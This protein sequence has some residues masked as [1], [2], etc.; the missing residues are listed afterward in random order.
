MNDRGRLDPDQTEREIAGDV[1]KI[2]QGQ[3]VRQDN[4]DGAGGR[5]RPAQGSR[6]QSRSPQGG[7]RQGAASGD[8]AQGGRVPGSAADR[9]AQ[10]NRAYARGGN[11]NAR[12][13][14]AGQASRGNRAQGGNAQNRRAGRAVQ[15]GNAQSG[16]AGSVPQRRTAGGSRRPAGDPAGSPAGRR[17][18]RGRGRRRETPEERAARIAYEKERKARKRRLSRPYQIISWAFIAIFILLMGNLV[19]F[20]VYEKDSILSSPYNKRQDSLAKFVVRGPIMSSDGQTLA[21]TQENADGT[22]TRIYP[23]SNEYAHVVGYTVNGKGGLE[24]VCNYDLLTAHNNLWDQ[25]VNGF[26]DRRNPGDTVVT[27]LDTRMQD[28]AWNALGDYNGAVVAMEPKTGRI[29]CM[30][31]KP[32][33]DPN[34]LASDWDSIVSDSSSSV[35][36]NRATQGLYAPGSTFKIITSLAYLRAHGTISDFS[37]DCTGSIDVDGNTIHCAGGEVHGTVDFTHAFAESC[38]TAFSE[39]GLETGVSG[40]T[41]AAETFLIGKSLPCDISASKSRWNLTSSDSNYIL[42][43]TA[44]GQAQTSVTPYQMLLITSAVANDGT[45]MTPYLIDRVETD[46]GTVISRTGNK[47]YRRLITEDEASVLKGLMEAVVSEGT[48]TGLSGQSYSAAGKTGTAQYT[49]SDGSTGT[50]SWF[51]GF[52]NVDD[53]DLAVAAIAENGGSGASTAL[54]IVKAVFDTYYAN[55]LNAG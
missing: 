6:G 42:A 22:D 41:D 8:A 53:P 36:L 38:N 12:D 31:S 7:R 52:S 27:T 33:F 14:E 26:E 11:R 23:Y 3:D 51:V 47:T 35:L 34:T 13:A 43:M 2:M 1:R 25:I 55:G 30:V 9:T 45:L 54:P 39:I 44:F 50:H 49:M 37:W 40:L 5:R 32:S 20:N 48:G 17:P 24:S 4:A 18:G 16:S 29:L 21:Y 19:Y 46:G 10:G 28:A 15:G